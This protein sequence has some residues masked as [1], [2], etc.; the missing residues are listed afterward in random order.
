MI[1][2][3]YIILVPIFVYYS[4]KN[5][6]VRDALY[7]GWTPIILAMTISSAGGSIMGFAVNNYADIAV[8]QP[9]VNGVGGNLVA[10]FA[11]RL[12]TVLHVTS[13]Q[14]TKANWSPAKWY[15]YPYDTF[16]ANKNPESKTAIVLVLLALPG[17]LI[18]FFTIS[19]IK[20]V[21]H[22]NSYNPATTTLAFVSFYLFVA[23]LQVKI[24]TQK[25]FILN[26]ID[27]QKI[28]LF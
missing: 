4:Y 3:I 8:F 26:I 17:H 2:I 5:D 10:I 11:S 24:K 1:I 6:F 19:K 28:K 27:C 18:F 22:E 16:F 15:L 7:N 23:F 14:G 13:T 21:N 12:S 25:N 20:M 9:V